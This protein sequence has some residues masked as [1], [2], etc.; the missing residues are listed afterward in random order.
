M[1]VSDLTFC[2]DF[3]PAAVSTC[4]ETFV[5]RPVLSL[6]YEAGQNRLV[7]H[8]QNH[9]KRH[10]VTVSTTEKIRH[11]DIDIGVLSVCLRFSS[12]TEVE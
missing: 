10:H 7:I 11:G 12:Y 3:L 9:G 5:S 8:H 2:V 4:F 1:Q 6:L